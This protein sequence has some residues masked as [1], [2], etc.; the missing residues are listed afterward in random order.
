M[1][2]RAPRRGPLLRHG[3]SPAGHPTGAVALPGDP[4]ADV[5][6]P[7]QRR[8][9][10]PASRRNPPGRGPV[11]AALYARLAPRP[12]TI[13][14]QRVG[15]IPHVLHS[16]PNLIPYLHTPPACCT[17]P[18]TAPP[19]HDCS[20]PH[21][22]PAYALPR[23]RYRTPLARHGGGMG[24]ALVCSMGHEPP[25][26]PARVRAIRCPSGGGTTRRPYRTRPYCG[27]PHCAACTEGASNRRR[28]GRHAARGQPC[29]RARR[30]RRRCCPEAVC[31]GV[32]GAA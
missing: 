30:R 27:N 17:R 5:V 6:S 8:A 29:V 1:L 24:P 2:A 28:A 23:S 3:S 13:R 14:T 9:A 15:R 20:T 21:T 32:V 26:G 4:F 12:Q 7:N 16:P 31:G 19:T 18:R 10:R 11:R 22:G 25:L